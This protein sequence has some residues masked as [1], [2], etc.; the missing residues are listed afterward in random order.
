MT[1]ELFK[2]NHFFDKK[3][4]PN[5]SALSEQNQKDGNPTG[6]NSGPTAHPV[7]RNPDFVLSKKSHAFCSLIMTSDSSQQ[8]QT[9]GKKRHEK[10]QRYCSTCVYLPKTSAQYCLIYIYTVYI[11]MVQMDV[12]VHPQ[13]W[14]VDSYPLAP[15]EDVMR[16]DGAPTPAFVSAHQLLPRCLKTT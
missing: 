8:L 7:V 9:T 10:V 2:I 11:N 12:C 13:A 16:S 5:P 14:T 6:Q 3:I 4:G 15:H 1:N